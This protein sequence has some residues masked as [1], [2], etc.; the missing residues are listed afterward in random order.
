MDAQFAEAGQYKGNWS[1]PEG[2]ILY[3]D[4]QC[5]SS[6][7]KLSQCSIS[8]TTEVCA[9]PA[10]VACLRDP[11]FSL[12]E[13]W[14]AFVFVMV[15]VQGY[16]ML[17]QSGNCTDSPVRTGM[18]GAA[19]RE[20]WGSG[21]AKDPRA[22]AAPD[23]ESG[24]LLRTTSIPDDAVQELS[25][26]KAALVDF[27]AHDPAEQLLVAQS[28]QWHVVDGV[29]RMGDRALEASEAEASEAAAVACS[30]AERSARA[31]GKAETAITAAGAAAAAAAR[32]SVMAEA[33]VAAESSM[34][35][36]LG[37]DLLGA[38]AEILQEDAL[39]PQLSERV[40]VALMAALGTG[41]GRR[42]DAITPGAAEAGMN[43][44]RERL[45]DPRP[46]VRLQAAHALSVVV[47]HPV[48]RAHNLSDAVLALAQRADEAQ[49]AV[50]TP[51]IAALSEAALYKFAHLNDSA[52]HAA[53]LALD[54][55]LVTSPNPRSRL[56][57][58]VGLAAA[59]TAGVVASANLAERVSASVDIVIDRG[60]S[61]VR[62]W[63]LMIRKELRGPT[64][65]ARAAAASWTLAWAT[66]A[67]V[68]VALVALGGSI[69][70]SAELAHL[71]WYRERDDYVE[72][73]TTMSRGWFRTVAAIVLYALIS[74]LVANL[75]VLRRALTMIVATTQ[76]W[77]NSTTTSPASASTATSPSSQPTPPTCHGPSNV[78]EAVQWAFFSVATLVAPELIGDNAV[79]LR[80]TGATCPPHVVLFT[81]ARAWIGA[82]LIDI[83]LAIALLITGVLR[84]G[85]SAGGWVAAVGI[86]LD[87]TLRLCRSLVAFAVQ[88]RFSLIEPAWTQGTARL[89]VRRTTTASGLRGFALYAP[90][91]FDVAWFLFNGAARPLQA[92]MGVVFP[93]AGVVGRAA[94]FFAAAALMDSYGNA[95]LVDTHALGGRRTWNVDQT[96][97]TIGSLVLGFLVLNVF[98]RAFLTFSVFATA[99]MPAA[100]AAELFSH[101][102]TAAFAAFGSIFGS[103]FAVLNLWPISERTSARVTRAEA[104]HDIVPFL[105]VIGLFARELVFQ[106]AYDPELWWIHFPLSLAVIGAVL[107]SFVLALAFLSDP[108][109]RSP[110]DIFRTFLLFDLGVQE[111]TEAGIQGIKP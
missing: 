69:A 38:V 31:Q 30:M 71:A 37:C 68:V 10:A 61:D 26:A 104:L 49:A 88:T 16:V 32:A 36:K 52:R 96:S 55:A 103:V 110:Y 8:T 56:R 15:L 83:P 67:P 24:G 111:H 64:P 73:Y 42:G 78:Y 80:L 29:A 53:L 59:A 92:L 99:P 39:L 74:G 87:V 9:R 94:A 100:A 2:A 43:A 28:L 85:L 79:A 41:L 54:S 95:G 72:P 107:Q 44:V 17:S 25:V 40:V 108:T 35:S 18:E 4:V 47:E 86:A 22:L 97:Y 101:S 77:S 7:W 45:F 63:A 65:A 21:A 48:L 105:V 13:F 82:T 6:D 51:V 66:W 14:V 19:E 70:F 90:Y 58:A 3:T 11:A 91:S 76:S 60:D 89:V 57:A 34:A 46:D 102:V 1:L 27:F 84:G 23:A 109:F 20:A 33:K 93:I 12:V 81:A 5:G 106:N 98:S 50:H 62:Q 75:L